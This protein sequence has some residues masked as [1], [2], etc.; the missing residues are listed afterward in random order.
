MEP[1]P[2]CGENEWPF[3]GQAQS[4]DPSFGLGA[5]DCVAAYADYN[6]QD[7]GTTVVVGEDEIRIP[8][9]EELVD[10]SGLPQVCLTY[11]LELRC[12]AEWEEWWCYLGCAPAC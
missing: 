2:Y 12:P 1:N 4:L 7:L 8:A 5:I 11:L 9:E 3:G 6:A 10:D